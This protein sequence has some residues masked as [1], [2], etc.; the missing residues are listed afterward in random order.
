VAAWEVKEKEGLGAG[1]GHRREAWERALFRRCVDSA[2]ECVDKSA[3]AT[4][5]PSAPL[6]QQLQAAAPESADG[7][8]RLIAELEAAAAEGSGRLVA[9]EAEQA[10]VAL[11]GVGGAVRVAEAGSGA[12]QTAGGQGWAEWTAMHEA[13]LAAERARAQAEIDRARLEAQLQ[14]AKIVAQLQQAKA[15]AERDKAEA[16]MAAERAQ[17]A[18]EA[19]RARTDVERAQAAL[20]VERARAEARGLSACCGIG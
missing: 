2:I 12:G 6:P 4:Q 8:G 15:E 16:Q 14:Q 11:S 20:Q 10:R 18:M 9:P 3:V 7:C 1:A 13:Q 5:A 19:E 17:A